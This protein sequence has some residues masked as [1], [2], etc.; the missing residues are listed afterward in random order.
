[1]LEEKRKKI[2]ENEG[3]FN[4]IL[5]ENSAGNEGEKKRL[6]EEAAA[7]DGAAQRHR[8]ELTR[9]G[10]IE[11][12]S[13]KQQRTE[14]MHVER[15]TVAEV[16]RNRTEKEVTA[17]LTLQK[18][19]AVVPS[20]SNVS[21]AASVV[22]SQRGGVILRQKS[23]DSLPLKKRAVVT[24]PSVPTDP[25]RRV[26]ATESHDTEDGRTREVSLAEH[27]ALLRE[28]SKGGRPLTK[29]EEIENR[30]RL[31]LERRQREEREREER[32]LQIE[33]KEK[34]ML[35]RDR[36]EKER[37]EQELK[38]KFK[39][40][41]RL[42]QLKSERNNKREETT[43]QK[44]EKEKRLK[45]DEEELQMAQARA[46]VARAKQLQ[47]SAKAAL[48]SKMGSS[49]PTPDTHPSAVVSP[50][51]VSTESPTKTANNST[52]SVNSVPLTPAQ[53]RK[54]QQ[55]RLLEE[56]KRRLE[57]RIQQELLKK[58]QRKLEQLQKKEAAAAAVVGDKELL[59]QQE[60]RKRKMLLQE[61]LQQEEMRKLK[62]VKQ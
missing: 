12:S 56:E 53:L 61:S 50:V 9:K 35:E 20:E 19:V 27:L 37:L 36:Q 29:E 51:A 22:N 42:L 41:Q 40:R 21:A 17:S 43:R 44:R 33:R 59:L 1:M 28:K 58:Q 30:K 3:R 62:K 16:E 54:Q 6:G 4:R 26:S 45:E 48:K 8:G 14:R 52:S 23:L 34:E 32:I 13:S 49:D 46:M 25:R 60:K 47:E 31:V 5:A 10:S 15:S 2:K 39:E 7:L 57:E 18:D 24:D 38:S 11:G 55:R